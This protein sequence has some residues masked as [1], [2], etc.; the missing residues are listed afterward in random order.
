MRTEQQ[1]A[2]LADTALG[3]AIQALKSKLPDVHFQLLLAMTGVKVLF[4]KLTEDEERE[5]M[6]KISVSVIVHQGD[7]KKRVNGQESLA[8]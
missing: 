3:T 6:Q 1:R 5:N 8:S 4:A 7:K 2:P